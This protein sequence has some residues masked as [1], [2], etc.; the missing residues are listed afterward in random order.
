MNY[1]TSGYKTYN[2]EYEGYGNSW[3]WKKAFKER[4]SREDAEKELGKDDPW[5]ILGIKPGATKQEIKK[6]Y[7][8]KAMEWHPDRNP[9]RIDEC[10]AMM[11][12]INAAYSKLIYYM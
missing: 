4:M 1:F 5:E 9:D 7:Y 2:P 6:A 8:K 12:R 11:K 3:D 10:E